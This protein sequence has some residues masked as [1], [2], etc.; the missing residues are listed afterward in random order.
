VNNFSLTSKDNL[1]L[2]AV[3]WLVDEPKF[4]I[5]LIHGLG[6]HS[7][8][9]SHVAEFYNSKGANVYALDLRGHGQ[10]EGKRGCGP[11]LD[12]FLDDIALLITEMKSGSPDLPWIM[13]AHS[14][15][16]N[17]TLKLL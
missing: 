13:Y 11:N 5:C 1:K 16:G 3:K 8:R 4:N 10:S 2:Y 7:N 14:M 17:L 9:Y 15:G 6:E 12:S